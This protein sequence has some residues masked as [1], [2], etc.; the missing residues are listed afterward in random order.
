MPKPS[1]VADIFEQLRTHGTV[2]SWQD[3]DNPA[4]EDKTMTHDEIESRLEALFGDS[5][6][7]EDQKYPLEDWVYEVNNN[8]TRQGYREWLYNKYANEE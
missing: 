4:E 1:K 8:D 6:W 3:E 5:P 2:P 7:S